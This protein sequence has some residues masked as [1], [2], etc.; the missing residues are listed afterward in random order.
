M[1]S[2]QGETLTQAAEQVLGILAGGRGAVEGCLAADV[3]AWLA[4]PEQGVV[5]AIQTLSGAEAVAAA[6]A[7]LAPA[8]FEVLGAVSSDDACWAEV[9]RR[10]NGEAE[11]CIAGLTY[12]PGGQVSRFVLLRAPLVPRR[13]VDA[14][15][16]VPDARPILER[17][18]ADLQRSRFREAAAHF[19]ADAVY[20]HPPYGGGTERVLFEGRDALW[21]GFAVDRG[22]SPARQIMT[23]LWQ[24]DDR[25]FVE[26]AIDGIPDGGTFF[27]TA[28]IDTGGEI[29]RYVAFY[30]ATRIPT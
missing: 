13:A 16:A 26:G 11:T 14:G 29:A 2:F 6:L 20:S 30:S 9:A 19:S 24:Q 12:G 18:F 10:G 15:E 27:S 21:R 5:A 22:P 1:T 3:R 23:G 4:T 25:V 7:C 28:Q 8:N 17:Y